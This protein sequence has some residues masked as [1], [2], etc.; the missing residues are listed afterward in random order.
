MAQPA[1]YPALRTGIR[2]LE[3]E[4]SSSL[5]S[6][7]KLAAQASTNYSASGKLSETILSQ[8]HELEE[9]V[10]ARLGKVS[11]PSLPCELPT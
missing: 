8:C 11:V 9:Q 5:S 10:G 1:T 7:S 2:T 3:N 6:Y 4:L